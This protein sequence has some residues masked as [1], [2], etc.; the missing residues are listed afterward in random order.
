[1]STYS[2]SP[3]VVD[4]DYNSSPQLQSHFD[5]FDQGVG[6]IFDGEC[7]EDGSRKFS[8]DEMDELEVVQ[9]DQ[10]VTDAEYW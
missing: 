1:H 3:F 8:D 6:S 2:I 4:C 10:D 7:E 9:L 5:Y